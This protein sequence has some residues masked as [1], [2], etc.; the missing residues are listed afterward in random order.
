MVK[1]HKQVSLQDCGLA[2][3]K[4][5][6]SHYSII[7]EN[8]HFDI[9]NDQGMSLLD[10]EKALK[11]YKIESDS[12]QIE[13][14]TVFRNLDYPCIAVINRGG[15]AHYIVLISFDNDLFKV[16]DP[17]QV[18]VGEL[19]FETFVNQFTG[20]LLIP[21]HREGRREP[22]KKIP[23]D[24]NLD[25]YKQFLKSIPKWQQIQLWG[26]GIL[27][28]ILPIGMSLLIQY[29]IGNI[30]FLD[31]G[32]Q[33]DAIASILVGLVFY[34]I[35]TV[36]EVR[37]KTDIE[38][39]FLEIVLYS[40]YAK[41]LEKVE[42][43]KNYDYVLGYFWNLLTSVI[44]VFQKFYLKIYCLMVVGFLIFLAFLDF[45]I[46]TITTLASGMLFSYIYFKM[47][48]IEYNQREMVSSSSNFTYLVES[49]LDG[50]YDILSFN[51]VQNFK[52][53][54]SRRISELLRVKLESSILNTEI[55]TSIQIFMIVT[56]SLFI[57]I[58]HISF[59]GS[60][61]LVFSNSMLVL[62][63]L[64][65]ILQPLC[66]AFIAYK[67][68]NYSL[69]Y[70]SMEDVQIVSD[71]KVA[72]QEV[73]FTSSLELNNLTATYNEEIVFSNLSFRFEM[74][75]IYVIKG[76]NGSGKSTLMRI[77]QGVLSPSSGDILLDGVSYPSLADTTIN[78]DIVGYSN[79]YRVFAGSLINNINFDLFSKTQLS[80]F[81]FNQF[82]GLYNNYQINSQ[83][84][85]LSFGQRQRLLILRALSQKDKKIYLLDEPTSNLDKESK[86]LLI[87]M[88]LDLKEQGKMICII[89]HD[90]SLEEI[91]TSILDL[92]K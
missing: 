49:S 30:V 89:T 7:P 18:T 82:I 15:L 60:S 32:T 74:G 69:D 31:F 29:I 2:C 16:S 3:V 92:S 59:T 44:G 26:Y 83:G 84:R 22:I 36:L 35:I 8:N 48:E 71:T 25:L 78:D 62:L 37:L 63:L 88:L 1:H 66:Q 39:K 10:V 14:F 80:N 33:F 41:K 40:Y 5:I 76:E 70:I 90:E 38:N 9:Q 85:N 58:S 55:S 86:K 42:Y 75:N 45:T 56:A 53:E 81:D 4:T 28:I 17:A 23:K 72:K 6:L 91:A 47:K 12:F 11:Y 51:K 73:N 21:R 64:S 19:D 68:A 34:K 67:K 50:I 27:K 46:F 20:I 65:T 13:D 24:E 54:F 43:V 79:D 77:L 87:E 61:L 52:E 57:I